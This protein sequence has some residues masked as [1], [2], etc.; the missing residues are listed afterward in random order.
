MKKILHAL[1]V[2]G[3][4]ALAVAT[5]GCETYG[6]SGSLGAII[7]AGAGAII[8]NQSGHAG[9]GALIGA[10]LGGLTGL[11]VHDAI[12][13]KFKDSETT[14]REYQYQPSQGEMMTF[15]EAEV[16]PSPV[17]RGNMADVS[18]QY[19]LLGTGEGTRVTETRVLKRGDSVIA[20]LSSKTYTRND[21]TWV[22]TQQFRISERLA[23]GEYT[24]LQT[25]RTEQSMISGTTTFIIN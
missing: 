18:I 3:A 11:V 22:S 14:A 17:R 1:I 10:A 13:K 20:Q 2:A 21:G 4:L 5:A 16:R 6:E 23:P 7:G 24:L 25:V 15:E 12:A 8:G 9:E 19:A